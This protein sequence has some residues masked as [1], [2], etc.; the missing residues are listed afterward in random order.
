MSSKRGDDIM[1]EFNLVCNK[2]GMSPEDHKKLLDITL[3]LLKKITIDFSLELLKMT[4]EDL[5]KEQEEINKEKQNKEGIWADPNQ[6]NNP[7]NVKGII[8][9]LDKS[10]G[11]K[12]GNC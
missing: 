1:K 4:C 8:K 3:D 5:K 6:E 11:D 10:T 7:G 12:L 9:Q 2:I